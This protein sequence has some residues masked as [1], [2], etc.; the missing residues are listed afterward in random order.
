MKSLRSFFQP[1]CHGHRWSTGVSQGSTADSISSR[2]PDKTPS[3]PSRRE[4][5][6]H[7]PLRGPDSRRSPGGHRV[8]P[9]WLIPGSPETAPLSPNDAGSVRRLKTVALPVAARHPA[10]SLRRC[11]RAEQREKQNQPARPRELLHQPGRRD[12]SGLRANITFRDGASHQ[13]VTLLPRVLGY[14]E[15]DT[16]LL[17]I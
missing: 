4:P 2:T 10:W 11:L 17:S 3:F 6:L 9:R 13:Q 14:G 8:Q 5:G 12:I 7:T 16:L 15:T 1:W